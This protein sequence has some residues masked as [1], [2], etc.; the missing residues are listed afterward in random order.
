MK[1]PEKP[2]VQNP[3][4]P[5][6]GIGIWKSRKIPSGKFRNS[7]VLNVFFRE[8]L[9]FPGFGIF[10]SRDFNPRDSEFLESRDFNPRK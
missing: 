9:E 6:I 8:F 10:C 5:G 3:K 4:I 2:L 7:G 1:I